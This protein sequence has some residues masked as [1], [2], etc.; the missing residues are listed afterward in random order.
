MQKITMVIPTYWGPPEGK[1]AGEERVFDHP[2]P[3]DQ[4]GTL[5]RALES[6][7]VLER[8]DFSI[9]LIVAS[10]S[11]KVEKEVISKVKEICRPFRKKYDIRVLHHENLKTL[12]TS[13]KT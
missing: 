1:D 12:R 4:E 2:T 3:L 9:V 6:L 11:S 7:N 5:G 13:L 10:T 8:S